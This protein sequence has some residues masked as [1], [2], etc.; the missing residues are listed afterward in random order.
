ME[1]TIDDQVRSRF[2]ADGGLPWLLADG[3]PV[4]FLHYAVEAEGLQ[5]RVPFPLDLRA[6]CAYVSVVMFV[7]DKMRT[8]RWPATGALMRWL[9]DHPFLNWR[10]YVRVIGAHFTAGVRDVWIGRPRRLGPRTSGNR[11]G[12]WL[13]VVGAMVAGVVADGLS[14]PGWVMMW[15]MTG[16]LLT[17]FKARML[18]EARSEG[19]RLSA[20][21]T[22]GYMLAW[23]GMDVRPF[24]G[25]PGKARRMSW[26]PALVK[27]VAGAVLFWVGARWAMDVHS[28]LAGWVGMIGM[29]LMAHFGVIEL[30]A[31]AWHRAGVPVRPLMNMPVRSVSV[32]EFWGRRW[33]VAFRDLAYQLWFRPLQ[34]RYGESAA[35]MGVFVMSGLL[36]ELAISVPAGGGFGL[37]FGYF[38][39]QGL[40]L[41][42]ERRW[43]R[44]RTWAGRLWTWLV[45]AGPVFWL[46]HPCFVNDLIL[47]FMQAA[48]AL[49]GQR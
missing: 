4:L 39:I 36:H 10:K 11:V 1:R 15:L 34:A 25:G 29:V 19:C 20:G 18:M 6:G 42:V 8:R 16:V 30:L 2:A 31:C 22:L 38:A 48:G 7:Q 12:G 3:E 24:A 27:T 23:P 40:G 13:A 35:V 45:V 21:R 9:S 49:G 44:G 28:M 37:P 43:L 47:P 41:L 32:A 14:W 5:A 33:N 26:W 46:F 17:G